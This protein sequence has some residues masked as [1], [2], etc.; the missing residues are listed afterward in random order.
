MYKRKTVRMKRQRNQNDQPL[1]ERNWSR[2]T[3]IRI[4]TFCR[5]PL[6][7]VENKT[8]SDDPSNGILNSIAVPWLFL[9]ILTRNASNL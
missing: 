2:I 9:T 5:E 4:E 6:D 3:G 8:D 7:C 1:C